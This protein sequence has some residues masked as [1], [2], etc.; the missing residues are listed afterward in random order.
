MATSVEI[1]N[2]AL[3]M[4]GAERI[5][6]LTENNKRAKICNDIYAIE[7]DS[8]LG[9]HPWNFAT[10][11]I[12]VA[13]T[14]TTP[15]FGYEFEYQ[16]PADRLRIIEIEDNEVIEY[17]IEGDKLLTDEATI[18]LEYITRE[19]DTSKYPAYFVDAFA[20]HLAVKLSYPLVQSN[21][22]KTELRDH[23][24]IMLKNARLYDAQEGSPRQLFKTEWTDARFE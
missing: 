18:K 14:A 19:E 22:L 8:I 13:K 16:L 6:S 11:R 10:K 3:Y 5:S 12:E 20:A 4:V 2:L 21:E 24:Q 1:C 15:E 23:Y 9:S 7:R 17:R